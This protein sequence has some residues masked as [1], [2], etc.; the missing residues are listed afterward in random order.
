MGI[1]F[2]YI[3]AGDKTE[4]RAIGRELIEANLAAC[5][6]IFDPMNSMY[7]WQGEV[8]DEQETVLIA[9]TTEEKIAA[10]QD[11]V[12]DI[13]SYDCPCILVF[14]VSAGHAPYMAWIKDQVRGEVT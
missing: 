11:K 3:T 14:P 9:K 10:L 7:R 13:H 4:A 1:V 2:V 6:N 12:L 8:H 5:V